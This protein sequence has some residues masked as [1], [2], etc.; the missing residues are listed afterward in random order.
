MD[1]P[2]V[3][4]MLQYFEKIYFSRK[5]VVC[6]TGGIHFELR[7][8]WGKLTFLMIDM[9]NMTKLSTLLLFVNILC[10]FVI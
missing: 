1:P 8:C 3:F 9:P 10:F 4:G 7:R 6:S 5:P 2:W